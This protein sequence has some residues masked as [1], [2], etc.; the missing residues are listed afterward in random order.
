V[1]QADIRSAF[2]CSA[3]ECNSAGRTDWKVC[4]PVAAHTKRIRG[5][6]GGATLYGAEDTS[7]SARSYPWFFRSESTIVCTRLSILSSSG[8]GRR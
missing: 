1:R 5:R 3:A 4:I 2:F 6:N 8:Q 7:D